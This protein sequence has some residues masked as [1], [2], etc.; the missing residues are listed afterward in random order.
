LGLFLTPF[1]GLFETRTG[2]ARTL[3]AYQTSKKVVQKQVQKEGQKEVQK[4]V[5]LDRCGKSL[6]DRVF[7]GCF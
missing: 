3:L 4:G 5:F 7:S 2:V 6:F 1:W